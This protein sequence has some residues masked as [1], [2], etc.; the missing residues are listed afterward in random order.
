MIFPHLNLVYPIQCAF[1]CRQHS[2][3]LNWAVAIIAIDVTR[4]A[5]DCPNRSGHINRPTN[6]DVVV[7]AVLLELNQT[8][9][10]E[11]IQRPLLRLDREHRQSA[12]AILFALSHALVVVFT[13]PAA[14]T[15]TTN[16]RTI[17]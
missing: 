11:S 7:A 10:L 12:S 5:I 13:D 9:L 3:E 1:K 15:T 14:A 16:R 4:L 8:T 6:I 2:F 17:W